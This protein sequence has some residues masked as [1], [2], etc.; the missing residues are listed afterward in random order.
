MGFS[1]LQA[2]HAPRGTL[3]Q[4]STLNG[5]LTKTPPMGGIVCVSSEG[6]AGLHM[7]GEWE[8]GSSLCVA[9]PTQKYCMFDGFLEK[10][11]CSLLRMSLVSCWRG[12]MVIGGVD[13]T[14][15]S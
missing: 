9:L 15:E 2:Q 4:G 3:C 10:H 8:R 13:I 11:S 1:P 6:E 14:I 7:W 12:S 5:F